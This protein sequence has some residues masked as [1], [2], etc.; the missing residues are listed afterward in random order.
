MRAALA[1]LICIVVQTFAGAAF[2]IDVQPLQLSRGQDVWFVS[3]HTLPMIAM[4]AALPAG[5]GYDPREKSGLASFAADMLDEGAAKLRATDFQTA[6]SNRAIRLTVTTDRDYLIVSLV[7]LTDNAKDAFQLLGLALSQP[8]F[9]ADAIN[10]VRT[11][12]LEGLSDQDEEPSSVA[13]KAFYRTFFHDHP[14]A[15]PIDGDAADVSAIGAADLK[16]FAATHWVGSGL[17]VA[18]S[19]DI[20]AS[21][22]AALLKSAFAKLPMRPPPSLPYSTH[23]GAGSVQVV[24]MDVPQPSVIFGLPGILRSDPEFLPGYIANYILGGGGFSSRLTNEVREKRGLTY[25]ISTSLETERKAGYVLGEVATK[26]GSVRQTIDVI[27]STLRGFAAEG[28]TDTE[29]AD[30]KTYLTGSFPLAFSSN[31]GI[32]SQLSTFQRIGLSVDYVKKRNAMIDSITL[33]QV[34]HAARRLFDPARMTVVVAGDLGTPAKPAASAASV[35]QQP[36]AS[37]RK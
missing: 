25:D 2:A 5:S 26:R 29:L 23:G 19:G 10:R 37:R 24:P 13:T 1:S 16:A 20:D 30:A 36:G 18:V 34:K 14:Y 11:Q 3:D 22:L 31:A 35:P 27:R 32:A 4:V 28:P 17:K 12:I 7:T 21:A 15:H 33:D 9:D 6:L 8:R